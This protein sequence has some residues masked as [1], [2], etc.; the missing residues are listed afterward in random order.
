VVSAEADFELLQADLA[1]R[2][3]A[4]ERRSSDI[5]PSQPGIDNP[6]PRC[7]LPTI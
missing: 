1:E 3:T 4:K 2:N 6:L 5:E 7:A